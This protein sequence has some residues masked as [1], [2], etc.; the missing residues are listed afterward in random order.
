MIKACLFDLNYTIVSPSKDRGVGVDGMVDDLANNSVD[1]LASPVRG[2]TGIDT[3]GN[4]ERMHENIQ[5]FW[6]YGSRQMPDMILPG[7]L[8]FLKDLHRHGIRLA[9]TATDCRPESV[10]S[11]VGL[12]GLFD[13]IVDPATVAERPDPEALVKAMDYLDLRPEECVAVEN[14][15]EGIEAARRAAGIRCL[16]VGDLSKLTKADMGVPSVKGLTYER[17][18]EGLENPVHE[19]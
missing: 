14:T 6:E 12:Y 8:E 16:A 10:L 7:A 17:L 1:S 3:E 13:Y 4:R 2:M 11:S 9:S 18:K 19:C 5:V 15:P